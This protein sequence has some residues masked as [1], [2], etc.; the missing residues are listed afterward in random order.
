M[1]ACVSEN[2]LVQVLPVALAPAERCW[3]ASITDVSCICSLDCMTMRCWMAAR[4]S[5]GKALK[6]PKVMS[7]LQLSL[8]PNPDAGGFPFAPSVGFGMT[9]PK[10]VNSDV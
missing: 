1:S 10:L 6:S 5:S 4:M 2:A 8:N 7:C 3:M 9:T